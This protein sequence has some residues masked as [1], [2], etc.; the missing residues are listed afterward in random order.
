MIL[1]KRSS[2][3]PDS[4]NVDV[5]HYTNVLKFPHSYNQTISCSHKKSI[6]YYFKMRH[7]L[8]QVAKMFSVLEVKWTGPSDVLKACQRIYHLPYKAERISL[9]VYAGSWCIRMWS[10]GEELLCMPQLLYGVVCTPPLLATALWDLV[11]NKE[12]RKKEIKR[13]RKKERKEGEKKKEKRKDE[14]R[15]GRKE[16]RINMSLVELPYCINIHHMCL[17]P[18]N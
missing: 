17:T 9:Q 14:R 15:E 1:T 13:K 3:N 2:T 12:G 6:C 10:R 7:F 11:R 8:L 4:S 18:N 5:I 16:A